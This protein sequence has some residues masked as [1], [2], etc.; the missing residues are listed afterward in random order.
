MNNMWGCP[1][2]YNL[3]QSTTKPDNC[4]VCS[5]EQIYS[6]REAL[7]YIAAAEQYRRDLDFDADLED[8]NDI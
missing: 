1:N 5:N 6:F 8:D 7:E 3:F 4:V 2:C